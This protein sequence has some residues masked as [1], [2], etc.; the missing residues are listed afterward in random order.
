MNKI[1]QWIL[2]RQ[3]VIDSFNVQIDTKVEE[4]RQEERITAFSLAQ[5]DILETMQDD[6]DKKAEE[7]AKIKL[8]ELLSPVDLNK[9]VTW[10]KTKGFVY[11]GGQRIEENRLASLKSEAEYFLGSELWQLIFETPKELAQR[12]MFVSGESLADLQ[13]GKSILYTLASQR[14]IIDVFKLYVAKK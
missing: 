12:S 14:N 5:K 13:K 6:L 7:L 3:F 10:D 11:I 8:S 2:N 9:I 1:K 4:A